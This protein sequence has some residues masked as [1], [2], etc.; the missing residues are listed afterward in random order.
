MASIANLGKE[1]T[2]SNGTQPGIAFTHT[3]F[4]SA[5]ITLSNSGIP[6]PTSTVEKEKQSSQRT[7]PSKS[8]N[9]QHACEDQMV[10]P[11]FI[12]PV[13]TALP[14]EILDEER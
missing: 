4:K 6:K 13:R 3:L 2:S 11:L 9:Y 5:T 7:N 14:G 12:P 1:A 10:L 8:K